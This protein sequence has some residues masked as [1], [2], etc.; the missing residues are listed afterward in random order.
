MSAGIGFRLISSQPGTTETTRQD[1]DDTKHRFEVGAQFS[2]LG[3]SQI[4]HFFTTPIQPTI[5]PDF[6]DTMTL[7]GFGGRFT[8]NITPNFAL[9]AQGDF[10]PKNN[11]LINNGRAGGRTL[12]GQAG[13]KAGKRFEKFGIFAKARPGIVSFSKTIK[14]DGFNPTFGFPIFRQERKNYFSMDIGG[15]LEFYPS[16]RIVTRFDGGDTMIRFRATDL[17]TSFFPTVEFFHVPGETTHNFQFSAGVG[18]RF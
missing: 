8:Y 5:F 13:V 14:V 12:Q 11:F 1:Q 9:E 17:P 2:S 7:A 15:V 16:P 3:F 18:Y 10:Y 6:R 4:E